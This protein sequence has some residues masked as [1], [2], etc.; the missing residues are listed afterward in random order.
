LSAVEA[1]A[2][3]GRARGKW[4]RWRLAGLAVALLL[5]L[6]WSQPP[7]R[8]VT[9]GLELAA[10][11]RYQAWISPWLKRGGVRCRFTPSCSHYA[12]AVVARDG[13]LAGN[14]RALGRLVRCGPWT[15]AGTV[16]PP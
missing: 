9:S 11:G 2:P 1:A 10:I 15:S 7:S 14:F 12:A 4:R 6:D 16:D 13:F 5:A 8:Q 3:T